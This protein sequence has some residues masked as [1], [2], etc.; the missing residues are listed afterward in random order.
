MIEMIQVKKWQPLSF[1]SG[2]IV[3]RTCFEGSS[4]YLGIE[5]DVDRGL[6]LYIDKSFQK[7][8]M[9]HFQDL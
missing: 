2:G 6:D 5:I 1:H 7:F 9:I 3:V 8:L 4:I